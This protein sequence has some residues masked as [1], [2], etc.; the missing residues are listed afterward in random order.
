MVN[1]FEMGLLDF[2]FEIFVLFQGQISYVKVDMSKTN[3][4]RKISTTYYGH[5]F[6][7]LNL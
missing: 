2:K 3:S 4:K 5:A 7:P 1:S 6:E